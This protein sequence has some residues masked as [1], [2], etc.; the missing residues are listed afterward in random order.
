MK[1]KV[2]IN[3]KNI[4]RYLYCM[5]ALFLPVEIVANTSFYSV[6]TPAAVWYKYRSFHFSFLI[7]PLLIYAL[8]IKRKSY[9]IPFHKIIF[10]IAMKDVIVCALGMNN[11]EIP[12]DLS[13]YFVLL[14]AWSITAVV[15]QGGG[16]EGIIPGEQFFDWYFVFAFMS[17]FLRLFL[18]MNT[19]GR[20]GAIGLGVGGTGFFSAVYIVYLIYVHEYSGFTPVALMIAFL[21]LI[22]SGQRTNLLFCVLF[23]IPFVLKNMFSNKTGNGNQKKTIFLWGGMFVGIVLISSV[24][25]LEEIGV[26]IPGME[27]ISRTF[28]AVERFINGDLSNEASVGGRLLSIEAGKTILDENVLG[29]TNV[30]YDLQ[31]RM[32]KL[33][34]PTYPHCG[35]LDCALLWSTPITIFCEIWLIKLMVRLAKIRNGMF[36]VVLYIQILMIVWGSPFLDYP[37]LFIILMLLSMGKYVETNN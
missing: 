23:C 34:Y 21:T 19:D 26:Q 37:M 9:A 20:Y 12:F 22:L 11:S 29:I 36:W 6:S 31:Y 32:T 10:A 17:M 5:I 1:I 13:L 16:P 2:R 18:G 4:F 8:F 24:I 28:D 7:I 33:N 35:V 30:F 27:F 25:L 14:I 15:M 3:K